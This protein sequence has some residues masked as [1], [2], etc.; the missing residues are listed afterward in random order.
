MVL[1]P[2]VDQDSEDRSGDAA[3]EG[4]AA[5][6]GQHDRGEVLAVV[7]PLVDDVV[8]PSPD[9][10]ARGHDD[11]RV[12]DVARVHAAPRRLPLAHPHHH[13][14]GHDVAEAVPADPDEGAGDLEDDRVGRDADQSEGHA[15]SIAGPP[16][17]LGEPSCPR[18]SGQRPRA[19]RRGPVAPASPRGRGSPGDAVDR[20]EACT[21]SRNHWRRCRRRRRRSLGGP[22]PRRM[23]RCRWSAKRAIRSAAIRSS[24]SVRACLPGGRHLGGQI[25]RASH[26]ERR[27]RPGGSSAVPRA[28]SE[29][30]PRDPTSAR[31]RMTQGSPGLRQPAD[32]S[33]RDPWPTRPGRRRASPPPGHQ[34]AALSRIRRHVAQN[35]AGARKGRL[36]LAFTRSHD[37]TFAV[38]TSATAVSSAGRWCVG[39]V[40]ST[41]AI[42]AGS[43]SI[44]ST[45][46]PA[47]SSSRVSRPAPHPR[48]TANRGCG[49]GPSLANRP[50]AIRSVS[51][52]ARSAVT[53]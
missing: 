16:F 26:A 1:P 34:R 41:T 51:Q 38:A 45:R 25:S 12:Q 21:S 24:R 3:V 49:R 32:R 39:V 36:R 28:Q 23:G 18:L 47:L 37:G 6:R 7:A 50:I 11:Q 10:G 43:R 4:E 35:A 46:H 13:G 9:D 48:S 42:A 5:V 30:P 44:A 8:Q 17:S 53:A 14:D 20:R 22:G 27:V 19:G 33:S 15:G 29:C 2:R 40:A 31:S 52:A